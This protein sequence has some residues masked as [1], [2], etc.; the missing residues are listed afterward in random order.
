M[1]IITID[2]NKSTFQSYWEVVYSCLMVTIPFDASY[3]LLASQ[4]RN[5]YQWDIF[6]KRAFNISIKKNCKRQHI[7]VSACS[8]V[9]ILR[10]LTIW[11]NYCAGLLDHMVW[12]RKFQVRSN[13]RSSSL[14]NWL[15]RCIFNETS[16]TK[17]Q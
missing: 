5:M 14:R 2:F 1:I 6:N 7:A 3:G 4:K 16:R 13:D 11:A 10:V 9:R 17:C 15:F 8:M 12:R